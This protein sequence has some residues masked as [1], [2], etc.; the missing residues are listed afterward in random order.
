MTHSQIKARS[1][2][3]FENNFSD[4]TG[5]AHLF[6]FII[7]LAHWSDQVTNRKESIAQLN[8][9]DLGWVWPELEQFDAHECKF[10]RPE[11]DWFDACERKLSIFFPRQFFGPNMHLPGSC[12]HGL[13]SSEQSSCKPRGEWCSTDCWAVKHK[14]AP[15]SASMMT[16]M[17]SPI[18][19][20]GEALGEADNGVFLDKYAC[21]WP[22]E[23]ESRIMRQVEWRPPEEH[24]TK[25]AHQRVLQS[26]SNFKFEP[27][28]FCCVCVKFC[29]VPWKLDMQLS[30]LW[31]SNL[32]STF[33][34]TSLALQT[35]IVD[36]VQF[37]SQAKANMKEGKM[38]VTWSFSEPSL[39]K[40]SGCQCS[41][42]KI[43]HRKV[44]VCPPSSLTLDVSCHSSVVTFKA[45]AANI[46]EVSFWFLES[47][48]DHNEDGRLQ[49]YKRLVP[50]L[51]CCLDW[52]LDRRRSEKMFL[53]SLV[54]S[55]NGHCRCWQLEAEPGT[56][57]AAGL[58]LATK[59]GSVNEP[60]SATSWCG[61]KLPKMLGFLHCNLATFWT[62]PMKRIT[63]VNPQQVTWNPEH[64]M[65][66]A[67]WHNQ[68]TKTDTPWTW[69]QEV[70][71]SVK[72]TKS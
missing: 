14:Q 1:A 4:H 47:R 68:S 13:G 32:P 29:A 10:R 50:E 20:E 71:A 37:D 21:S 12:R 39:S 52:H 23:K 54:D 18:P 60:Q 64:E 11:L 27:R 3:C 16:V 19:W 45:A 31:G 61:T 55:D 57:M 62:S 59:L 43:I 70:G 36:P 67:K 7:P 9:L 26:F 44:K 46:K 30:T 17:V 53:T 22:E 69:F 24:D 58:V 33:T 28:R 40:K 42:R 66:A 8:H 6:L 34:K 5:G 56:L 63:P 25:I 35:M 15:S 49:S 38:A 51:R 2:Y 48:T 72:L 65:Q 41:R